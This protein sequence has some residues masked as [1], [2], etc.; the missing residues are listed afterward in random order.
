MDQA[1]RR[2]PNLRDPFTLQVRVKNDLIPAQQRLYANQEELQHILRVGDVVADRTRALQSEYERNHWQEDSHWFGLDDGKFLAEVASRNP[3]NVSDYDKF[4]VLAVIERTRRD[5]PSNIYCEQWIETH[6]ATKNDTRR[7]K[8][9]RTRH[10]Q[11]IN[12]PTAAR[13]H[14]T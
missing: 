13:G 10:P 6:S 4:R 14:Q 9:A 11:T 12:R 1:L 7:Y 3:Y 8:Q 2:D 5:S